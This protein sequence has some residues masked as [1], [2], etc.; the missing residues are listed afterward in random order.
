MK[1]SNENAPAQKD[2]EIFMDHVSK[3]GIETTSEH[4]KQHIIENS[5]ITNSDFFIV[6]A[7]VGD[8]IASKYF[9]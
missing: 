6:D 9:I 3:F 4:I 8:D 7:L 2:D 1:Q 5:S